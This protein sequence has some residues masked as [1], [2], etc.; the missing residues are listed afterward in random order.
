MSV[1]LLAAL[2]FVENSDRER[3]DNPISPTHFATRSSTM[4]TQ[5]APASPV[6]PT[7]ASSPEQRYPQP[8]EPPLPIASPTD[9]AQRKQAE[10]RAVAAQIALQAQQAQATRPGRAA[11]PTSKGKQR[12]WKDSDDEEEELEEESEDER[13][14][15]EQE[16]PQ[17]QARPFMPNSGPNAYGRDSY[18]STTN[19]PAY[20]NGRNYYEDQQQ[21][22]AMQQQQA[23]QQSQNR[24]S[25]YSNMMPPSLAQPHM[26]PA[27]SPHGLL[28]AGLLDKADRSAR[29][30]EV[31]ARDTGGPLVNI[32]SKPPPPQVGL[33]GA[34]TSHQR[35]KERAGGVGRALTEQQRDRKLAE[36]RQKQL[37]ENQRQQLLQQ[38]Q[39]MQQ[40]GGGGY[41]Q[42]NPMMMNPMMMNPWMMGGYGGMGMP[43]PGGGMGGSQMGGSQMGAPQ[44]GGQ[45]DPVR[46][47]FSLRFDRC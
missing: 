32:P 46:F 19:E 22:Q 34:I 18:Y 3:E 5:A 8:I 24:H 4:R 26:V 13:R 1:Q 42:M 35:E 29:N 38:Q 47:S 7:T 27:M 2:S 31:Q 16:I 28:H 25:S 10:E 14:M 43:S 9:T 44:M 37:D 30:Q 33:V 36:Q 15:T 40:Y 39:Q 45:M 17:A 23:L 6:I 41:G 11:V 20:D 21:Q 12:A